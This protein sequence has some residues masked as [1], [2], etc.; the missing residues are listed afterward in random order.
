MGLPIERNKFF[1]ISRCS[2]LVKCQYKLRISNDSFRDN[3][4]SSSD[5][6][7]TRFDLF[8]LVSSGIF[9]GSPIKKKD[10]GVCNAR[11]ISNSRD[12]GIRFSAFSYF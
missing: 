8:A 5:C 9:P 11:P 3:K 7:L 1:T 2:S 10:T 6:W 12:A 4:L